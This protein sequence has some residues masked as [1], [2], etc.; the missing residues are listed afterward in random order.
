MKKRLTCECW[1]GR[2]GHYEMFL[3]MDMAGAGKASILHW[4]LK[5]RDWQVGVDRCLRA[6]IL[7]TM[8][9]FD[10]CWVMFCVLIL[11][12]CVADRSIIFSEE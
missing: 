6:W 7:E 10:R 4:T 9:E 8:I 5:D 12:M 3:C 1:H 2:I 11:P